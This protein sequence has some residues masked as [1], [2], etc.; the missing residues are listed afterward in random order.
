MKRTSIL[1]LAIICSITA[2]A[3]DHIK[4]EPIEIPDTYSN[5]VH[6]RVNESLTGSSFYVKAFHALG[7][8]GINADYYDFNNY[9]PA[10][11]LS[12]LL[13]KGGEAV[14]EKM[15]A[16]LSIGGQEYLKYVSF[17]SSEG[18]DTFGA[19]VDVYIDI[20]D[21][22]VKLMATCGLQSITF[23]KNGDIVHTENFNPIEQ[24]LWRRTAERLKSE[25]KLE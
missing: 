8:R 25:L 18:A 19:T 14:K 23:T 12:L 10:Y 9:V 3:Q 21:Y 2:L 16:K 7:T 20:L 24:E 1:L 22:H 6:F 5:V 11:S 15:V 17:I 13:N 4:L